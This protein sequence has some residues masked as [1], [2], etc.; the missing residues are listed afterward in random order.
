MVMMLSAGAA[1]ARAPR[2]RG[3]V[4]PPGGRAVDAVR[5]AAR[6]AGGPVPTSVLHPT[7]GAGRAGERHRLSSSIVAI[8]SDLN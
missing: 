6:A 2:A 7:G 1:A 3:L 8:D 4:A 5:G